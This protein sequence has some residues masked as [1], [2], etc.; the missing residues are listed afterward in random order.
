MGRHARRLAVFLAFTLV[1]TM[2]IPSGL[3]GSWPLSW[4]EFRV[5]FA[6]V[7]SA[8][9]GVPV[10]KFGPGSDGHYAGKSVGFMQPKAVKREPWAAAKAV[11]EDSF[12]ENTSKK[13]S[14]ESN[15]ST[16]VY[17]N[18][19]GSETAKVSTGRLNYKG[20]DGK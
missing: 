5:S 1:A 7:A 6:D 20:A 13:I 3:K 14:G 8:S 17:Q 19:D 2:G 15:S 10:Q 9:A 16:D 12:D 18:L 11:D 4:L